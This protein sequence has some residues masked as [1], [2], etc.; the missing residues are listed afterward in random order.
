MNEWM[1]EINDERDEDDG[2]GEVKDWG[3]EGGGD[4]GA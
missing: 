2:A 3:V 1:D 4:N